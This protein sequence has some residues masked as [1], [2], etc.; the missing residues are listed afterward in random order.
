MIRYTTPTFKFNIK[1]N[2]GSPYDMSIVKDGNVVFTQ[3]EN[4]ILNKS[5]SD[6][7][8]TDNSFSVFLSQEETSKF[9]VGSAEVQVILQNIGGTVVATN[10][11]LFSVKKILLEKVFL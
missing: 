11:C 8:I 5:L 6:C 1:Q 4:E 2:D 10:P 7:E 9:M 3:N